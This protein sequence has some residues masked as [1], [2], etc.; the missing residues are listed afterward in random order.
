ALV[1]SRLLGDELQ[2]TDHATV[3]E[4]HLRTEAAIRDFG[5]LRLTEQIEA[6]LQRVFA[7][8]ECELIDERLERVRKRIALRRA[9]RT[10]RD[11]VRHRRHAEVISRHELR[12]EFRRRK[13]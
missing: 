8:R 13:I 10:S 11:A 7:S 6:E 9:Q 12:G 2:H 5:W 1:P 4:A 3:V